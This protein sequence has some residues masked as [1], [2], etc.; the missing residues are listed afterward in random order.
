MSPSLAGRFIPI[1]PQGKSSYAIL[2]QILGIVEFF[3]LI[4]L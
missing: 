4:L 3:F 1:E 2:K